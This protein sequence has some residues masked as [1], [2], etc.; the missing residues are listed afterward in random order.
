ML[1]LTRILTVAFASYLVAVVVIA[2]GFGF[3]QI[4]FWVTHGLVTTAGAVAGA[5]LL[6]RRQQR[7]REAVDRS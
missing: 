1:M 6:A 7:K 4:P 2:L 5:A 3:L